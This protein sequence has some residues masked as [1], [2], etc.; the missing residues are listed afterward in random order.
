MFGD[1]LFFLFLFLRLRLL[2]LLPQYQDLHEPRDLSH[3]REP[4]STADKKTK[5]VGMRSWCSHQGFSSSLT[6]YHFPSAEVWK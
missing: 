6:P 5:T 1:W 2:L 4:R 3:R